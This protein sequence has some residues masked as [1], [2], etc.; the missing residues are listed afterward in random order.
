MQQEQRYSKNA[1]KF[2]WENILEAVLWNVKDRLKYNNKAFTLI[3]AEIQSKACNVFDGSNIGILDSKSTRSI[4][5]RVF[6]IFV[7]SCL[8]RGLA[9]GRSPV[10]KS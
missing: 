2:K 10:Q 1:T 3:W 8:G 7:L 4:D 6:S 5:V 9:T